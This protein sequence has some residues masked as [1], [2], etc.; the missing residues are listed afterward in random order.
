MVR[1]L[2]LNKGK[3]VLSEDEVEGF[4]EKTV[5]PIGMSGKADIPRRYIGRRVYV[6]ITKN[7]G[8]LQGRGKT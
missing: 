2:E 4:L 5:T 6:I 1:R 8:T 7:V 3:L